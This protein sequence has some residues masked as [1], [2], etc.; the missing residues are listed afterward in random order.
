MVPEDLR[1]GKESNGFLTYTALVDLGATYNFV[2]QAVA[3]AVGMLPAKA[4]RQQK[5][6]TKPP[7]VAMVN[8]QLLCTAAI[9]RHMVRIR[10]SAGVKRCHTINLIVTDIVNYNVTLGMAW[11][12]KQNSDIRWDKG[13]WHWRTHTNAE[14]GLIRLVSTSAFIVTM[15]A[16]CTQAYKL[17]LTNFLPNISR[18]SAS[19]VFMATVPERTIPDAYKAYAGVFSETDSKSPPTHSPQGLAIEL[20]DGKQ[21]PCGS[22]YNLSKK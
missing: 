11:L 9:V 3:D 10:N 19:D 13:L 14:D 16:D 2:S 21:L 1:K 18:A 5:V 17:H 8:G 20:L 6:V 22:I 7:M 15:R 4:G 12:Q